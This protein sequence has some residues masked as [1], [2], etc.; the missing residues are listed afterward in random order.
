M[1]KF[2]NQQFD[3]SVYIFIRNFA[4]ILASI[5]SALLN[6]FLFS[7]L[8]ASWTW[9]LIAMSITLEGTKI[10][11]ITTR[12]CFASIYA[13][14][15]K[16]SIKAKQHIFMVFYLLLG[17]LSVIAGLGFSIT[18]TARTEAIQT[19]QV[20]SLEAQKEAIQ[21]KIIEIEELALIERIT[22]LEYPEYQTSNLKYQEA[23]A[24]QTIA[25]NNYRAAVA[26]RSKLSP[27]D[28]NYPAAQRNLNAMNQLLIAANEALVKA[29][30]ERNRVELVFN[31]RKA[32]TVT[33]RAALNEELKILISQAGLETEMGSVALIELEN[34]IKE[35]NNKYIISKGMGYMFEEFAKYLHT[36]PE[37]VKFWIL[38]FVAI[39]IELTIYQ[40][41]PDI[42]I[43]RK[44]LYFFRNSLP[45]DVNVTE[46]LKAF[47]SENKKYQD[48]K[49]ENK[50][51][52]RPEDKVIQ[53]NVPIIVEQPE[54][55]RARDIEDLVKQRKKIIK[56]K[57]PKK[58]KI[59]KSVNKKSIDK[60]SIVKEPVIKEIIKDTTVKDTIVKEPASK[61][62][63]KVEV[64]EEE[65]EKRTEN[66]NQNVN[67]D[68]NS[69]VDIDK[70]DKHEKD[71]KKDRYRFGKATKDIKDRLVEFI[72]ECIEFEGQF[73]T[74][75][76]E[77]AKNIKLNQK[78]KEVFLNRLM[79]IRL[80][81]KVLVYKNQYDNYCANFPSRE[82]INYVTEIVND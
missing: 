29:R 38:L 9:L 35:E 1:K 77:A 16:T 27:D 10:S 14:V 13:K 8:D 74:Q 18:I 24:N 45:A 47:D 31:E 39:L 26:E 56:R 72:N 69:N 49:V 32:D 70:D 21:S 78:A 20:V 81:D 76:N 57:I 46:V 23:E 73:K 80:G 60:K 41:S 19:T 75:P 12:N 54:Q 2:K 50:F 3:S 62:E 61:K 53:P 52:S 25:N 55:D 15:K 36:T 48:L 34:K 65:I 42:R 68:A 37:L 44:V 58:P 64:I 59:I 30:T 7:S 51:E 82:I 63:N 33:A 6:I 79:N 28:E 17:F 11:T 67:Q 5:V 22:I 40:T 66:V 71:F 4:F 43:T